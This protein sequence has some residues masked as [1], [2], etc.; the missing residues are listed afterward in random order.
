MKQIVR[1][2]A[3]DFIGPKPEI[4]APAGNKE[5]FLAALAAGADAIYCGLK[6]F[7]ARMAA[8]NFTV[9]ELARLSELAHSQKTRLY[10]A[11]NTL[12]KPEELIPVGQELEEVQ[13]LVQPDGLIVQDLA[14]AELAK[15]AGFT[16]EIHLSTLANVTMSGILQRLPK[17]FGVHRVVLP[18][19][20]DIEEVRKMAGACPTD[21]ALEIFVHGAL[22]YGVSWREK[23]A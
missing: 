19:E 1:R 5:A 2:R 4:L 22:C 13:R 23:R 3:G 14:V 15:Q 8:Q 11:F 21:L 9:A 20:L 17:T 12:L 10:L 7:S 16:G 6:S 18:R